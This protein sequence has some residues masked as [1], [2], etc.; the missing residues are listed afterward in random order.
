MTR[1]ELF[2][3]SL[4]KRIDANPNK[5]PLAV[6]KE[7]CSKDDKTC[8]E[9]LDH[10]NFCKN[11]GIAEK[12]LSET[13][14]RPLRSL[15]RKDNKK[16]IKVLEVVRE[17]PAVTEKEIKKLIRQVTIDDKKELIKTIEPIKNKF[18]IIVIDPPW[19]Y[20]IEY[21]SDGHRGT[22]DYPT[23]SLEEIKNINLPAKDNCVLWLWTTNTF[24]HEA[25]HI[26]EAWGFEPKT[27]LTWGKVKMGVGRWLRNITEHCILA[28]RG[29]VKNLFDNTKFTTL[30]I[31]ERSNLHSE[32]PNS[33]YEMVNEICFG[34]K[35]DYFGRKEKEGWSIYGV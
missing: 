18:D 4:K 30:L 13:A 34:N 29:N 22:A 26:L 11:S 2:Y 3:E 1:C 9:I 12:Q 27:I 20:G 16:F 21:D 31:E 32:K 28:T 35:I 23:M 24:M 17:K 8:Y 33:F 14:T 15:A 7:F 10:L 6:V 5:K 25:F 19:D